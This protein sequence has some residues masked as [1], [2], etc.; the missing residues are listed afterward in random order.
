MVEQAPH[1]ELEL[2]QDKVAELDGQLDDSGL[3]EAVRHNL[4]DQ[5][6]GLRLL[7][8]ADVMTR[9]D[10]NP[11]PEIQDKELA[12]IYLR[13]SMYDQLTQKLEL[14][15]TN[16][17]EGQQLQLLKNIIDRDKGARDMARRIDPNQP[18]WIDTATGIRPLV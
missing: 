16:P 4:L 12:D 3:S 13:P 8:A 17:I 18:T 14:A 7:M 9:L 15:D 11:L 1:S 6:E 10:N 5:R 2:L